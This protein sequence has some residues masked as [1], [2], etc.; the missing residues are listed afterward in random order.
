MVGP[1]TSTITSERIWNRNGK[2]YSTLTDLEAIFNG[3]KI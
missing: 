3:K 2:K 1:R